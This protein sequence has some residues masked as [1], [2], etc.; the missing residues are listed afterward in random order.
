MTKYETVLTEALKLDDRERELLVIEVTQSLEIPEGGM[1]EDPRLIAEL[2]RRSK[3]ADE[4]PEE[5][6]EWDDAEKE[7]FGGLLDD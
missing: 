7:I 3:H 5:L 2:E 4:H 1:W 6:M